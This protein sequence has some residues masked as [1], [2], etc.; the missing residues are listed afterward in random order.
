MEWPPPENYSGLKTTNLL[1]KNLTTMKTTFLKISTF[2][3]LFALIGAGCEKKEEPNNNLK[4]E[5]LILDAGRPATDGCGWV[6][7]TNGIIYSPVELDAKFQKDSLKVNV[8]YRILT[9]QA[10]CG[11]HSPGYSMIEIVKISK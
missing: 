5:G 9:T 4:A 7:K 10:T 11:W 6:F 8:E 1:T 3:L 2:I